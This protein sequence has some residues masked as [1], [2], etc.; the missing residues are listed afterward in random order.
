[1]IENYGELLSNPLAITVIG[2]VLA[3]V[4]TYIVQT[5]REN[6]Q[7]KNEY[8][9]REY[10]QLLKNM[11][12]I[13]DQLETNVDKDLSHSFRM[14]MLDFYYRISL[15]NKNEKVLKEL[16]TII[17]NLPLIKPVMNP[18]DNKD[19]IDISMLLND[20]IVAVGEELEL[21]NDPNMDDLLKSLYPRKH[22]LEEKEE[23]LEKTSEGKQLSEK[24]QYVWINTAARYFPNAYKEMLKH[25]VA[26]TY[27]PESYGN[28][29]RRVRHQDIILLYHSG[30]GIIAKGTVNEPDNESGKNA[31]ERKADNP[32]TLDPNEEEKNEYQVIVNWD[33]PKNG[34]I[35]P[36]VSASQIKDFGHR[37]FIPTVQY[38]DTEVGE[39]IVK[40]LEI[41]ARAES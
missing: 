25:N 16:A 13:I 2:T 5:I 41:K 8:R 26:C 7:H 20:L 39:K 33:I 32:E 36:I 15:V 11:G 24:P 30:T 18:K 3:G 12:T 23:Q 31:L 17:G 21:K 22:P 40:E 10:Q 29:L 6:K 34:K 27:G 37:L 4:V 1:M 35:G 38:L 9:F 19:D 28:L 14:K